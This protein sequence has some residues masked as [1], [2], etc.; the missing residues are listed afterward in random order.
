MKHRFNKAL[1]L[2]LI[3]I[4]PLLAIARIE[5]NATPP[6]T[7]FLKDNPV[8]AQLDSLANL[9]FFNNSYFTSDIQKL[10]KYNFHVDSIPRYTDEIYRERINNMAVSS[11]FEFIYN[12]Q[13]RNFI[14]VYAF[15]K[16]KLTSRMLGLA[17]LYF[18]MFEEQ[19]DIYDVPIEMKYLAIIES[20]LNPT[21][22]S[23]AGATGLWQFMLGTGKLY[24]LKVTSLVDDRCDPYKSTI[25]ACMH[26][27][28]LFKIYKDWAL[29]LAAYNAGAGT[30]NRAIRMAAIDSSE[31]VTYW[32]I[33]H[34]LP[35]ETQNYVP[36][37]IAVSY[38]MQY[39]AEHN[40]YPTRPPLLHCDVD[41]IVLNKNY[42]L[43]QISS[44]LCIPI[45]NIQFL[46]PA[47]RKGIIPATKENPYVLRL[48]R[49]YMADFIVNQE[50][51]YSYKS[52]QEIN[53]Q[54]QLQQMADLKTATK[55]T[56]GK[57]ETQVQENSATQNQ[58]A[59]NN[60]NAQK[61]VS[62][63]GAK[64]IYHVVQKGDSLW[65]I[66]S[67]YSGV[68][69]EDIRRLN[70]LNNKSTIHPGQKLKIGLKS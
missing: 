21:A 31:K 66:A 25:A 43:A 60:T 12:E 63:N 46:N 62:G 52:I 30:V 39:A 22:R 23:R 16:R 48:P 59:A 27:K 3:L 65:S 54:K 38:V 45:E 36:A 34:F 13:V 51:I 26:L 44:F 20:A 29:C 56:E 37:F 55:T 33:Q 9:M 61:T 49:E 18:P 58:P 4:F 41:T 10:N 35:K 53:Y 69:I 1:I 5:N 47:Y 8:V 11:P 15:K 24:N 50:S 28:D 64:V 6:D 42:T 70:N 17:E 14:E 68:S 32:K 2:F 67:K 19:L 40:I 7:S 57:P